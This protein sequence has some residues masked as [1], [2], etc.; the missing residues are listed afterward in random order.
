MISRTNVEEKYFSLK[1]AC[2]Y[3][4][5]SYPLC[6]KLVVLN[7]KIAYYNYKTNKNNCIRIPLSELKKYQ[8]QNFIGEEGINEY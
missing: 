1:E 5:I 6:Y 7:N 8:Q 2:E 3:L 4:G